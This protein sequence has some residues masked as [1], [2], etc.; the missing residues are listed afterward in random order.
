VEA[1]I[2]GE[3]DDTLFGDDNDN[4]LD[5]ERGEDQIEADDGRDRLT[6]GTDSDLLDA[7]DGNFDVV[8]CEDDDDLAIADRDDAV[9]NCETVDQPGARQPMVGRSARVRRAGKYRLRLP[10]GHRFFSLNQNLKIP[11][12]ST[13]NPGTRAVR[14]VTQRSR[15]GP[16]QV[17][18]ISAG[19]FTVRQRGRRRAVTELRLAGRRPDCRGSSPRGGRA[20]RAKRSS[21]RALRVDVGGPVPAPKVSKRAGVSTALRR[22]G[23]KYRYRVRG[24]YSRGGSYGTEWLTQDR[25]DGTLTT[26]ISGVVHVQDF[27]RG[28]TVTVRPGKPYLAAAR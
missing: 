15:M 1:I 19:R 28:R 8:N 18:S 20:R 14:L 22:R 9:R 6:G 21:G 7:H 26:V 11:L 24:L 23:R 17:A 3:V 10:Q 13:V 27:G 4:S 25:C 5:G 2:G 12:G 16:R